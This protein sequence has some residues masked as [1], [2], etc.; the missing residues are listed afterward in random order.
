MTTAL[1]RH[2]GNQH[3]TIPCLPPSLVE[4]E[5][6]LRPEEVAS[7][8][9]TLPRPLTVEECSTLSRSLAE[10]APYADAKPDPVSSLRHVAR[11]LLGFPAAALSEAAAEARGEAYEVA[12]E[13]VPAWAVQAGARRWI[14]G[15]VAPCGDR[16]NLAFPPSPPQLRALA[17]DE[18]AK[19]RGAAWRIRRLLAGRPERPAP[20]TPKLLPKPAVRTGREAIKPSAKPLPDAERRLIEAVRAGIEPTDEMIAAAEGSQT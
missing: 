1:D 2:H 4:L 5:R 19:T 11:L 16:V 7:Q 15:D 9:P 18:W 3:L 6:T 8:T 10:V 12:I 20:R 13:D 17:M 14:R